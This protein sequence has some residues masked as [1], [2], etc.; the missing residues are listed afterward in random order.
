MNGGD[1]GTRTRGLCRDSAGRRRISSLHVR[2]SATVG[3][4]GLRWDSLCNRLATLCLLIFFLLS[5]IARAQQ[6]KTYTVPF[7]SVNG[8][9]LLDAKVNG[10]PAVLL[11][12][13]G[14]ECLGAGVFVNAWKRIPQPP[15]QTG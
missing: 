6:T 11:L 4:V 3:S 9:I 7:H 12:D 10:K 1:D 15:R 5:P 14:A 2:L 8:L 13:T